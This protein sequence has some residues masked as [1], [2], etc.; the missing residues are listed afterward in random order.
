MTALTILAIA[1][2]GLYEAH[3][4]A[5]RTASAATDGTRARI[6]AQ[7]LLAGATSGWDVRPGSRTGT[8]GRF[9]WSVEVAREA[10]PSSAFKSDR[11]RLNR[12]RVA[13]TWD[14]ARR[15]EFETLKLGRADE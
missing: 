6:I 4:A 3:S 15:V 11:W 2:V 10:V 12:V 13:V 8:D 14:R 9:N 7:S 1:F 5:M